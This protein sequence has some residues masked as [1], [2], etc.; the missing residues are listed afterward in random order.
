[1][2]DVCGVVHAVLESAIE[3]GK[4]LCA[5]GKAHGLAEV[6]ATL[7]AVGAVIAHDAGLNGDA[8]AD[9]EVLDPWSYGG[10]NAGGFMA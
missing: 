9:D 8:L 3:V 6:V 1:M 2:D 5:A 7:G 10:D 4:S